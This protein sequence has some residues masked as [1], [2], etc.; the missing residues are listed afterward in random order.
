VYLPNEADADI[1]QYG[2]QNTVHPVY[3]ALHCVL[4]I[5]KISLDKEN[6]NNKG[7]MHENAGNTA[8]TF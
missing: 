3:T 7:P 5:L 2:H 4:N 1:G 6:N 8:L